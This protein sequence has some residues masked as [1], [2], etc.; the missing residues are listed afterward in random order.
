[1]SLGSTV[2]RLN[3]IGVVVF[4]IASFLMLALNYGEASI[5][6][7][8]AN[9]SFVLALIISVL[10]GMEKLTLK[11]ALSILLAAGSIVLLANV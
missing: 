3:T 7:P 4:L 5:V 2:Y 10:L 9:M 8:V 1:M 11:K 6:I